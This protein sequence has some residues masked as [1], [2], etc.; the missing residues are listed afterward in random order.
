MG[1]V[2]TTLNMSSEVPGFDPRHLHTDFIPFTGLISL[3]SYPI[4][5]II[6]APSSE[7]SLKY[8]VSFL[9]PVAKAKTDAKRLEISGP[10]MCPAPWTPMGWPLP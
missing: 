5:I 6:A 1:L 9:L 10:M 7:F 4:I 2:L 8:R 3:V